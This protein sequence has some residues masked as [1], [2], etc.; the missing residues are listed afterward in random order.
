[1]PEAA[2]VSGQGFCSLQLPSLSSGT[3]LL[4]LSCHCHSP[5]RGFSG[6]S[7][8]EA[9]LSPHHPNQTVTALTLW[10]LFRPLSTF[11]KP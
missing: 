7:L 6:V 8:T 1:M 4:F 11:K 9:H 3:T 10:F 2:D 5:R